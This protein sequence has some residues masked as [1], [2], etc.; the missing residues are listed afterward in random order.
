MRPRFFFVVLAA[1]VLVAYG[2]WSGWNSVE[3][4]SWV[5]VLHGGA[6][7]IAG[8]AAVLRRAWS[9]WLG[10]L[11]T[12][13]FSLSWLY[14]VWFAFDTGVYPMETPLITVLSMAP[15]L[16]MI[17]VA[18]LCTYIFFSYFASGRREV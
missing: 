17:G 11:V 15:G 14:I 3:A 1:L 13:L 16:A 10:L 12:V 9:K 8:V 7:I 6:A 5:G 4:R 18:S 2:A